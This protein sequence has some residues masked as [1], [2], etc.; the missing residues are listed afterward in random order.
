MSRKVRSIN[1]RVS[2][3]GC[4]DPLRRT[5]AGQRHVD[6]RPA[7][8]GGGGG[9][10]RVEVRVVRRLQRVL[11][12]VGRRADQRTLVLRQLAHAAQHARDLALAAKPLDPPGID[13]TRIAGARER[14]LRL[15]LECCDV[16]RFGHRAPL[17][18]ATCEWID[19]CIVACIAGGGNPDRGRA[20]L[21]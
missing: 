13:G 3:I 9:P 10:Q 21:R 16:G 19:K 4:N 15:C 7:V 2:V 5:S 6:P 14:L 20:L 18:S 17:L 12:P 1:R 11:Q 8:R